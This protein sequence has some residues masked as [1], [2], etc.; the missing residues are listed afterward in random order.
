MA[1]PY[2]YAIIRV[3]PDIV[4]EEFLNVG[5][6]VFC[7]SRG[8]LEGAAELDEARIRALAPRAD[9]ELLRAHVEAIVRVCRGEGPLGLL[10]ARERFQW[11]VAP[12]NAV[13]QTSCAH[14][15]LTDDPAAALARIFRNMVVG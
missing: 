15:G 7:A 4:R 10:P 3:V 9:L 2:E 5:A 6:V 11:V 8:Y 1:D 13:V 14:G 12:R